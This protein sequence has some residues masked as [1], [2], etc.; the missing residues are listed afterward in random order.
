M[1]Q[2]AE[3]R[4]ASWNIHRGK[5]TDGRVDPG[6][7]H[8]A[9]AGALLAD[10]LD[11]LALQEADEECRPHGRILKVDRIGRDTGLRYQHEHAVMRWGPQSDGFLGTIL[12]LHPRFSASHRDVI[13]LPGH[14]HRGAVVIEARDGPASFRVVS[15]HL[16]LSQPLRIIQMRIVGQYLRRRPPMQT[17]LLGDFNEWRP[18]GGLMFNRHLIGQRFHG[19]ALRTFPSRYPLLPLDRIMTDRA[20]AVL[21]ARAI[22]T[23][24]VRRAS[25]HLPITGTITLSR[26]D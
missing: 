24:E 2:R 20:G 26:E 21:Q 14:C 12:F 25:D 13:D 17:I 9:I 4:C 11:V 5:G 18:W 10:G 8:A 3:L 16:S 22:T 19:P 15:A 7:I 6:R 23:E 1:N